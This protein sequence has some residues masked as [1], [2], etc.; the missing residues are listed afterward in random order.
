[1]IPLVDCKISKIT[2]MTK[3]RQSSGDAIIM[4][5]IKMETN[6]SENYRKGR[7]GK[8]YTLFSMM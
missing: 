7:C 4:V 5:R 3:I 2:A 6:H 8:A 1:V